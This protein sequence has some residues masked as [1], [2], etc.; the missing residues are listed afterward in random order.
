MIITTP[1]IGETDMTDK[2]LDTAALLPCPF[3]GGPPE[4]RADIEYRSGKPNGLWF[5]I[6]GPC[7]LIRDQAWAVPR[8]E[9][10][11][12]WNTRAPD[13]ARKETDDGQG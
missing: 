9:A 1:L 13:L 7:D 8:D 2:P 5:V 10:I 11:A 12:A 3:C 4:L 6:C